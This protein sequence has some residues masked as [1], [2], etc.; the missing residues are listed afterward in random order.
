MRL[1]LNVI[2]LP[3][4]NALPSLCP[5]RKSTPRRARSLFPSLFY[6]S[7]LVYIHA[8]ELQSIRQCWRL[9]KKGDPKTLR[10]KAET[11]IKLARPPHQKKK[12]RKKEVHPSAGVSENIYIYTSIHIHAYN[13]GGPGAN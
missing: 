2:S 4:T 7:P 9:A 13:R 10:S 1:K 6:L 12:K 3:F 8:R 11:L 5:Q